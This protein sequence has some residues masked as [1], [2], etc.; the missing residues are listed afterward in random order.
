MRVF[1]K[2]EEQKKFKKTWEFLFFLGSVDSTNVIL[3]IIGEKKI[4]NSTNLNMAI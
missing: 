3:V 4:I 2:G 1:F